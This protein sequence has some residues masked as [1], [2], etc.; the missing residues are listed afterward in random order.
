MKNFKKEDFIGKYFFI[1][2]N[3]IDE[4]KKNGG[5]FNLKLRKCWGADLKNRLL[6]VGIGPYRINKM[7]NVLFSSN[8]LHNFLENKHIPH[9]LKSNQRFFICVDS[10]LSEYKKY[11]SIYIYLVN[12]YIDAFTDEAFWQGGKWSIIS[13]NCLLRKIKD[14]PLN[15]EF[16][17]DNSLYPTTMRNYKG[18]SKKCVF[19]NNLFQME[20]YLKKIMNNYFLE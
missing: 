14:Y 15:E 11:I 12:G 1:E 3:G 8:N 16:E 6:K 4:F 18:T 9:F 20:Q 2:E 17:S 5:L 19:V 7:E 10:E 13:P